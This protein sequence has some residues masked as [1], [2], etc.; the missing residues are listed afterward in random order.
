MSALEVLRQ[1]KQ[2]RRQQGPAKAVEWG[3]ADYINNVGVENLSRHDLRNHLEA[4][5]LNSN[6]TRIEL[7]ERLRNSLNDE[8][9]HKFAYVETID[10][11]FLIEAQLEE[12]GSVYVV[13]SNS[14]GQLGVGDLE[15]RP[16]FVVIPLLRGIGVGYVCAGSDMCYAV[17]DDHEVYV[18]GGGGVG[19]TGIGS[20]KERKPTRKVKA[21]NWMEPTLL[22]EL[23]GEEC[24]SV[25]VGSD[26]CIALGSS[27]DCFVWGNGTSGQLGL[28]NF[29]SSL[30]I[31]INNSF[32]AVKQIA[33]GSNHSVACTR[34]GEVSE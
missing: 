9:L 15:S 6:G 19:K 1:I 13:G 2:T 30:E 31:C 10:T 26:H 27:G 17:T 22:K 34:N 8:Q 29:E 20:K 16:Y 24:I 7:V 4:R 5:D 32:G 33:A 3:N 28:G 14:M 18:W 12:R 21:V 25:V 11:E 23:T